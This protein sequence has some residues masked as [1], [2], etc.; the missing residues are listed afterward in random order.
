MTDDL[1]TL[2]QECP[3]SLQY[4]A[5][6][7]W[8]LGCFS[9]C[10][11]KSQKNQQNI[12]F[13]SHETSIKSY[14]ISI[15]SYEISIKSY[16]T[17]TKKNQIPWNF[18]QKPMTSPN[19]IKSHQIPQ[20]SSRFPWTLL[21]FVRSALCWVCDSWKPS[22]TVR[23]SSSCSRARCKTGPCWSQ[24]GSAIYP[25]TDARWCPPVISWFIN[26]INYRYIYHKP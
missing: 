6:K 8:R 23:R 2:R 4:P 5:R 19:P 25:W 17:S 1:R 20:D 26:P 22:S 16:E 18:H 12:L 13:A 3:G 9:W 15:K 10:F 24:A 21:L 14:E 7:P 11:T